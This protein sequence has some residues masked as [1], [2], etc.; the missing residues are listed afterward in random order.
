M[1]EGL[2]A[3]A[4]IK[5]ETLTFGAWCDAGPVALELY[6]TLTGIQQERLEDPF[7][8]VFPVV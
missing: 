2:R 7:G 8:W 1:H 4:K 3:L 5:P 6:E